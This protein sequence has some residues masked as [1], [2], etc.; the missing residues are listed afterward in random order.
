MQVI[1]DMTAIP[2]YNFSVTQ[3][4]VSLIFKVYATLNLMFS[5]CVNT[6]HFVNLFVA[7]SNLPLSIFK[8]GP[9]ICT[10]ST[11]EF[12]CQVVFH[13]LVES[14][15]RM[16]NSHFLKQSAISYLSKCFFFS[17]SKIFMNLK[18]FVVLASYQPWYLFLCTCANVKLPLPVRFPLPPSS[19]H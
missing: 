4:L 11:H 1:Y 14:F 7:T 18:F 12:C 19:P 8:K 16:W 6:G 10:S 2:K 15:C 5:W 17:L 9:S 3:V 13:L